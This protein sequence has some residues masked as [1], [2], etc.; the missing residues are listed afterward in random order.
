MSTCFAA[1]IL[2]LFNSLFVCVSCSLQQKHDAQRL[3]AVFDAIDVRG[4]R[5]SGVYK[6]LK[7]IIIII[8]IIKSHFKNG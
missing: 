3:S 6:D 4:R 1:L 8:S 2:S 5:V 7:H